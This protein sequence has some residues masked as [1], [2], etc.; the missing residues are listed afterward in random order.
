MFGRLST[1]P[2]QDAV[3]VCVSALGLKLGLGPRSTRKRA[4]MGAVGTDSADELEVTNVCW[5]GPDS[6]WNLAEASVHLGAS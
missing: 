6:T 1:V 3:A 4:M 5:W 2:V